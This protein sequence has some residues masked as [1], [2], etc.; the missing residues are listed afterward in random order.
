M[1]EPEMTTMELLAA[2][3]P[4]TIRF[5]WLPMPVYQRPGYYRDGWV[6]LR[7]IRRLRAIGFPRYY[8]VRMAGEARN[9]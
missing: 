3:Y 9:G 4:G 8:Y 5:A 6:W 2:I 1:S 7:Q